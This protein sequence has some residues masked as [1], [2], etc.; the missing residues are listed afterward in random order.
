MSHFPCCFTLPKSLRFCEPQ[1]SDM[2]NGSD[3][4][5]G[6]GDDLV[7]ISAAMRFE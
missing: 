5:G 6:N 7:T 3:D 1:F 4:V 2:S